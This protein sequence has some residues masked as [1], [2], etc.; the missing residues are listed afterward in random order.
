VQAFQKTKEK[1]DVILRGWV[2]TGIAEAVEGGRHD[3]SDESQLPPEATV[4]STSSTLP[5]DASGQGLAPRPEKQRNIFEDFSGEPYDS[6]NSYES[7]EDFYVIH[8][9]DVTD[10]FNA[11][12]D[13]LI[14][15]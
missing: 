10:D 11:D 6:E 7:E 3:Q 13:V 5:D 1:C 2:K 12:Y 9:E 4:A 8:D 14:I 15:E